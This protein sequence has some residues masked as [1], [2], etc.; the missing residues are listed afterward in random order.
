MF[1][2]ENITCAYKSTAFKDRKK[3][4]DHSEEI[5]IHTVS[6]ERKK[7]EEEKKTNRKDQ[8]QQQRT[9]KYDFCYVTKNMRD[10]FRGCNCVVC[11]VSMRVYN[12]M[13]V[14]TSP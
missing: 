5:L 3:K 2:F 7:K 12:V 13:L 1:K 8:Q 6:I 10:R 9:E 14:S 4:R 11:T